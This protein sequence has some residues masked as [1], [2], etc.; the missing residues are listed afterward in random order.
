MKVHVHDGVVVW[1]GG[2]SRAPLD[3][4]FHPAFGDSALS[5]RHAFDSVLAESARVFVYD[6]PGH[7]ASPPRLGGLTIDKCVRIWCRLI[8]QFSASRPTVLVGHSMAGIIATRVA[9]RLQPQPAL[10]VGV[11]ANLTREDAY[12]SGRAAQ[13]DKPA[14]FCASLR[15]QLHGLARRDECARYFISSLEFADAFTLWT[16]G[17]SVAAQRDPGAA[18][19]GLRC[20][21]IHYWD[22]QGAARHTREYIAHYR[23][24]D[25]RL[26]G[27]GHSPMTR[28]PAA[29]Y[30]AIAQDSRGLAAMGF[31]GD[32]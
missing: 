5:Y 31:S 10:V 7:G 14:A 25:R 8:A 17:R 9:L 6:P 22:A 13:F 24:P 18:F 1:M 3:V 28:S 29:F 12:F 11:E 27:S 20:P 21:K 23:L 15:S 16:L 30:T 2:R 26:D 32:Y 4:W 19:R